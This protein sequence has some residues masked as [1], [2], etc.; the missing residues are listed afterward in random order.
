MST[1]MQCVLL[2]IAW[3]EA[4]LQG[5]GGQTHPSWPYL[6]SKIC[7]NDKYKPY[8]T[9][10]NWLALYARGRRGEGGVAKTSS[11]W[12]DRHIKTA[13]T[14]YQ[15]PAPLCLQLIPT[16]CKGWGG[17][18]KPPVNGWTETSS[19]P[20]S[21]L[22]P[23]STAMALHRA[24]C[25]FVSKVPCSNELSGGVPLALISLMRGTRPSLTY[26]Q[27]TLCFVA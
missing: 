25:A 2:Q 13:S 18:H 5:L 8:T 15:R 12:V 7:I 3:L 26:S 19:L 27:Q 20:C 22:N 6:E 24:A 14:T 4:N 9:S 17:G 11:E 16:A 23:R 21:R 10:Y 1:Y